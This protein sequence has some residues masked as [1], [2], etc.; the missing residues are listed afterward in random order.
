MNSVCI[1]A[2]SI[3]LQVT[4]NHWSSSPLQAMS[5]RQQCADMDATKQDRY[6]CMHQ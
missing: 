4:I 1:L 3:P 2:I 6:I 5:G